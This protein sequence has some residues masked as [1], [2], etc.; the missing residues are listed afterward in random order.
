MKTLKLLI[1]SFLL[2]A[3]SSRSLGQTFVNKDS[4]KF[5][6]KYYPAPT[7]C[8]VIGNMIKC[9][10]YVFTWV[11]EPLKDLPRHQKEMLDQIQNPRK[12]EVKVLGVDQVGYL[13]KVENLNQLLIIGN[14]KGQCG[15]IN[16]WQ[17]KP[18]TITADLPVFVKQ[19]IEFRAK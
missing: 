9:N 1:L 2:F 19:L 18:I 6:E 8:E 14:I 4:I 15:I 3:F 7:G 10:D 16:L 5:F 11:Y 12:I 17:E 13:T